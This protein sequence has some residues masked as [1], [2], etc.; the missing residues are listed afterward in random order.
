MHSN[1]KAIYKIKMGKKFFL[2]FLEKLYM[3]NKFF[4]LNK[5][6]YVILDFLGHD[7]IEFIEA[8]TLIFIEISS[9]DH[10]V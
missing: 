6:I 10:F 8:N 7:G 9:G 4:Y 1:V 3:L 5:N 2:S